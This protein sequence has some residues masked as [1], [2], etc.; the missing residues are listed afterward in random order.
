MKQQINLQII[1]LMH[2]RIVLINDLTI[3]RDLLLSTH[4]AVVKFYSVVAVIQ[5]ETPRILVL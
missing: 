5:L 3:L 4:D 2:L 1:L